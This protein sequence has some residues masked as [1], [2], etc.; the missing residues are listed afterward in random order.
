ML[1]T[2]ILPLDKKRSRIW[3]DEEFAFVLYKGELRRFNIKEGEELGSESYNEIMNE[4]LPKR[5]KLRAM[6]LLKSHTYTFKQLRDK[7]SEGLYPAEITELA[8]EYVASYGYL[9]DERL[10]EEYIRIHLSDKSKM[11]IKQDLLRKGVPA[12]VITK[13]F[14][15]CDDEGF[16]PDEISQIKKLL[17]KRKFDPNQNKDPKEKAKQFSYLVSKGYKTDTIR[18]VLGSYDDYE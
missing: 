11:R 9:D 13:A 18:K 15:N 12:D 5:A 7:L 6:N 2:Q 16:V 4:V 1:V 14:E 3:L 17:E 10:A 8:I